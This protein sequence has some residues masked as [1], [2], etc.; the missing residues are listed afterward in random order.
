M[1]SRQYEFG[2]YRLDT[3]AHLLFRKGVRVV[4]TP[5]AVDLLIALVAAEGKPIGKE[6]LLQ[7]VWPDMVVEEGSLTSHISL[8]RKTLGEGHD[9]PQ[10]IETIPKRGYRF[11][12]PL[13]EIPES[14]LDAG[15]GR[16]MLAVLPFENL[17][18][19][20]KYDYFSDGLTEEMITQLARLNPDQLGVIARTSA[21]Q[22]QSTNKSVQQIGRELR[23]SHLL[24]GSVRRAADRVRITAQLIRVSDAT[25]LWAEGYE[26]R[27]HDILALQGEVARAVAR[28][29]QIKLTLHQQKRLDSAAS[30][31]PRAHEAY[32]KGRHLWN[33]RTEEGMRKSITLYEEAIR[34]QPEYA[35]AYAGI[36]DSYVMLACRGMAPAKET[37]RRAK[38]A[39]RKALDLD[40]ELGEAH[41]SLAHV[42]LHDWDWEGLERDFQRAIQ[43]NPAEPIVYYW[44]GEFLMS[45]GR[46]EEAILMTERAHQADPL[47]PVIGSSLAM[48]LYLARRYDQA[49]HVL[50]RTHEINPNHFLP[51]LRMG[52][53]RIQQNRYDN[54][55]HELRTA[56]TL[57]DESTE[58]LAALAMAYAA[59]RM[60]NEA[61]EITGGLEKLHGR[62]YVLPYNIAKI[63]AAASDEDKAFE[64][65]EK[66]Y[67]GG[68]PDLI[69]LNSEPLFDRLRTSARFSDLMGRIGF[70]MPGT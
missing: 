61:E 57:A 41:G 8:L 30:L 66:A 25:H 35:I 24:E 21:M 46:P 18:G 64:W 26:R 49:V 37:F 63:Y 65:L 33:R 1:V 38:A 36:A 60:T 11:V 40:S 51:H 29:I 53:V 62:R 47:S 34:E 5:K 68:N 54:A 45:M 13:N 39:A 12:C 32:L 3:E 20:E 43:L 19:G 52:L 16:M 55:I 31:D 50:D 48:I 23:V 44:Y 42:R 10:F 9:E 2:Q 22:Y 15:A 28:E 69:E 59:A 27:L 17:S 6:D 4:L 56:V 58:T 7:R 14:R 70:Q 67:E